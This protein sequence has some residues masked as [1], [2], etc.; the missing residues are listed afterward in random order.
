VETLYPKANLNHF[1]DK[2]NEILAKIVYHYLIQKHF[3]LGGTGET[4]SR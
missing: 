4:A 3:D 1:N 2:G